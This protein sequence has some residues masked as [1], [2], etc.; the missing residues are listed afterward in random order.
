MKNLPKEK[1]DRIILIAVGTLAVLAGLYL[2]VITAQKKGIANLAKKQFEE[3]NRIQNAQRLVNATTDIKDKLEVT[4]NRLQVIETS[5]ASGDMYS[6]LIQTVN[7]FKESGG[8]KV[9]IPQ[10]SRETPTEAGVLAK[11]PYSAVAFN[12]R[13]T[14]H[15][16]DL[17]R[18]IADFENT[19][20]YMRLQ[21]LEI[22]PQSASAA[23]GPAEPEKVS[24]KLE[25][26]ALVKPVNR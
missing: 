12:L 16:H 18:F 26:V 11:F 19:F 22:E 5:M 24:F 8:Y 4:R 20:P 6:W 9:E 15:Y 13:G 2:G 17:G 7:S 3:E 21:N 25:V 10:F 23:N 14:A 1:R